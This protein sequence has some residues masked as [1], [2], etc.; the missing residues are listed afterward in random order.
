MRLCS[1][2]PI[3][4]VLPV[5][6]DLVQSI[7]STDNLLSEARGAINIVSSDAASA[8]PE[9]AD[10]YE[11]NCPPHWVVQPA[12]VG[13]GLRFGDRLF[14]DPDHLQSA[15]DLKLMSNRDFYET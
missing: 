9:A 13:L 7:Q 3:F 8:P 4:S 15:S 6:T 10:H 5:S 11:E 1:R 14:E 2:R 12:V